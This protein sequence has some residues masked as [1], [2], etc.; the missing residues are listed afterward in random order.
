MER[1]YIGKS[2][3]ELT[4]LAASGDTAAQAELDYRANK[5]DGKSPTSSGTLTLEQRMTGLEHSMARCEAMLQEILE[6]LDDADEI[7]EDDD[8]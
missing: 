3:N 4:A 2:K 7:D 6:R 5:K 1:P 8:E